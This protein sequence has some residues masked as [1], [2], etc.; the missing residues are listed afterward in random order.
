MK[1]KA[2]WLDAAEVFDAWRITPR[3]ILYGFG[4][5]FGYVITHTMHWYFGLPSAERTGQVTAVI[6]VIIPSV[7]GLAVWVYKI[8]SQ[9][10]RNWEGPTAQP[11]GV[12]VNVSKS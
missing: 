12:T 1:C 5:L 3:T 9:G 11:D 7:S 10:G 8:Y 4:W 6:G 2:A